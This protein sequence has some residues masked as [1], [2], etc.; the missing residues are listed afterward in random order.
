MHIHMQ[1]HTHSHTHPLGFQQTEPKKTQNVEKTLVPKPSK[2]RG[3][4]TI[5]KPSLLA[6]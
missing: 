5:T 1:T 2:I 6:F 4:F 3:S